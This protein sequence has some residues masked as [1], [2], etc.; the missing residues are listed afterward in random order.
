MRVIK[1]KMQKTQKTVPKKL[2]FEDHK[3]WLEATLLEKLNVD[4]LRENHEEFIKK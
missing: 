3:H 4:S 1:T 2:K